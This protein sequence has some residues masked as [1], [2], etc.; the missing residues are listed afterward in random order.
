T[1][2][3]ILKAKGFGDMIADAEKLVM[4]FPK[5]GDFE[6]K[7]G[8]KYNDDYGVA[9]SQVS[10]WQGARVTHYA[11]DRIAASA[12]SGNECFVPS[13][14]ISVVALT[15]NYIYNGD[16]LATLTMTENI[17]KAAKFCSTNLIGTPQPKSRFK[18]LEEITGRKFE[19]DC[20]ADETACIIL[21]NQGT[22]FG[23]LGG[24]EV[25][26]DN[27]L[28]YLDGVTRTALATGGDFYLNP[29]WSSIIAAC[30]YGRDIPNLYF[31][32]SMLLSTQNCMQFR[33][34]LNIMSEYLRADG[35][36]AIYEIN[37]GNGATAETF[38][39]CAQ[40]L[41]QSKIKG[42]SL[43]AHMRINPDLG[44]AG[45]DWT[46]NAYQVLTSGVN[47][48][49]KYE[50]D[51]TAREMDTMEAYFMPETE[52]E[53]HADKIGDVIFHKSLKATADGKEFMK[54]GIKTIFGE[55]SY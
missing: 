43:A 52:R 8:I 54:K 30:Y 28:V 41:E 44:I 3:Q 29:S 25:A 31:K 37:I 21:K 47:M 2:K 50:S 5:V 24:V 45:F 16:L 12:G 46:R 13:E 38:I 40:E 51:G 26:N 35:T 34:L 49:Y 15:D 55:S 4:K 6:K 18:K 9:T 33:M 32:V 11:M 39:K 20:S 23:N 10:G 27:H 17:M 42:V 19:V 7:A 22:A 53:I 1:R 48:T 14:C 36:S